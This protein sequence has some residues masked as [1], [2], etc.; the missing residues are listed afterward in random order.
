[1][2][3]LAPGANGQPPR[4][5]TEASSW[6]TPACTAASAL[7]SRCRGCCGSARRAQRRGDAAHGVE[8]LDHPHRRGRADRVAETQLVGAA[9]DRLAG[10]RD[11]AFDRRAPVERAVPGGGDD[12][13]QRPPAS[14][15]VPASR[16]PRRPPR[17]WGARR[18]PGC[19]RRRRTRRTRDRH[20]GRDRTRGAVR[21]RPPGPTRAGRASADGAGDLLGVGHAGYRPRRD[22]RGGLDPAH[23][24]G[25][26][27]LEHRQLVGER[28]RRLDLQAVARADLADVDGVRKLEHAPNVPRTGGHAVPA[29]RRL[30][31]SSGR[32]KFDRP[33]LLITEGGG[34]LLS[35]PR[36]TVPG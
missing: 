10:D 5:P 26:Q 19:G 16:P 29:E 6:V 2:L 13:L 8:Q 25:R 27:R 17:R 14:W 34:V 35:S 22:E 1:M 11:S 23:A 36:S 28:H 32:S 4:P 31:N 15:A 3:P 21:G 33:L 7:A 9:R 18:W 12:D 20:A 24:G 30:I